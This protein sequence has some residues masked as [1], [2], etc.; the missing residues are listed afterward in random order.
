MAQSNHVHTSNPFIANAAVLEQSANPFAKARD[1]HRALEVAPDAAPGTYT[2]TLVKSAP[3]VPASEVE[4]EAEAVEV[5]VMW[6]TNVIAVRHLEAGK[7]F[8]VGEEQ[9]EHLACDYFLPAEKLG[10]TR[11]PLVL[12]EGGA[13]LVVVPA[14]ARGFVQRGD[15]RV[16]LSDARSGA[17]PCAECAGA[18]TLPLSLGHKAR[19]EIGDFTFTVSAVRAGKRSKRALF[20][21]SDSRL[22]SSFGATFAAVG[23]FLAS[24][25]YFHPALGLTDDEGLDK[26]NLVLM[27]QFLKASAEREAAEQKAD[28]QQ[29]QKSEQGGAAGEKAK[30]REGQMG[31]EGA[32]ATNHRYSVAK[33]DLPEQLSRE[34]AIKEAQDFGMIGM[35]TQMNAG[36][37]QAPT[38]VWG[39]LAASGHDD[40]SFMG[41]MFGDDIGENGGRNGLGLSGDGIGGGG[42]GEGIGLRDFGGGLGNGLYENGPGGWGRSS[43]IGG[44]GHQTKTPRVRPEGV[45][46]VSGRLP[47]EVI[48]RIVRQNYGRFKMCYERGLQ[49]NPNLA[50]RV[51]TRFVI[52]RD[53][54]VSNVSNG[55]SDLPDSS[56][57]GCVVKSFYGLSF[58]APT[59]GIVTVVYP[60]SFS[61]G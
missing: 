5:T 1:A 25:A 52:G 13:T 47:A 53:G 60:I 3:D 29:D 40:A 35:L 54:A 18:V 44:P 49:G 36:D 14:G 51:A 42:K 48:Q 15:A 28:T 6:G 2:Y 45:T 46:S 37:T 32:P 39:G 59:D 27:Q 26:Q 33:R 4:S 58:P 17:S 56:V 41:A 9:K 10:S 7:S 31:K 20:A 57:V 30:D 23:A 19:V 55:G 21:A 50:G 43:K 11:M 12:H 38:A 61:P 22:L 34:R 8:Y 24:M 16:D